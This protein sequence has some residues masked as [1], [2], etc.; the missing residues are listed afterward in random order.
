MYLYFELVEKILSKYPL[1]WQKNYFKNKKDLI[2]KYEETKIKS[3]TANY[4][5]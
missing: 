2:V 1:D 5:H 4:N 3:V